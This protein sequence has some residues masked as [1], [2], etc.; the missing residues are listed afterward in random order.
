MTR[1]E[2]TADE[3]SATCS[4]EFGT[5]RVPGAF[6]NA[7]FTSPMTATRTPGQRPTMVV[8]STIAGMKK[9]KVTRDWVIG[10]IAQCSAPAT[11]PMAAAKPKRRGA[12]RSI[13]GHNLEM[14]SSFLR[15]EIRQPPRLVRVRG[16]Y[17]CRP[18]AVF[19]A[20]GGGCPG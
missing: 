14:R 2:T 18:D 9:M 11:T 20:T 4:A 17:Q 10:K 1:M 6:I 16:Y 19:Q 5:S 3:M 8:M 13:Q 15:R 12:D 7:E